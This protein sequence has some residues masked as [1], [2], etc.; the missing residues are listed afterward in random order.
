MTLVCRSLGRVREMDGIFDLDETCAELDAEQ[1]SGI[2]PSTMVGTFLESRPNRLCCT[3]HLDTSNYPSRVRV[4]IYFYFI[5]W[6]RTF[7]DQNIKA[8]TARGRP[9]NFNPAAVSGAH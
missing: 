1:I 7:I 3:C 4:P 5:F 8:D 2:A 9:R 6:K